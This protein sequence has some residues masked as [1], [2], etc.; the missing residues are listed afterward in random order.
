MLGK[1]KGRRFLK[2]TLIWTLIA[3]VFTA[4]YSMGLYLLYKDGI[5]RLKDEIILM[6]NSWFH[7]Y[8]ISNEGLLLHF[9]IEGNYVYFGKIEDD[10]SLKDVYKTDYGAFRLSGLDN[11]NFRSEDPYYSLPDS[12]NV[13]FDFYLTND[14]H[15]NS[16]LHYNYI[17]TWEGSALDNHGRRDPDGGKFNEKREYRIYN[18]FCPGY[19]FKAISE[20]QD[21]GVSLVRSLMPREEFYRDYVFYRYSDYDL[22]NKIY[23][24]LG[25]A[26][27]WVSDHLIHISEDDSEGAYIYHADIDYI[28]GK[29]LSGELCVN[30]ERYSFPDDNSSYSSTTLKISLHK[31]PDSILANN[32]DLLRDNFDQAYL[33]SLKYQSKPDLYNY[34]KEIIDRSG[35]EGFTYDYKFEDGQAVASGI[36]KYEDGYYRYVYII[37]LAGFWEVFTPDIAEAFLIVLIPGL[38]IGGLF[39]S[40]I[41]KK[42]YV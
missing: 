34:N 6:S 18:L 12:D 38:I 35:L 42:R 30:G 13:L 23:R 21:S 17:T 33:E 39:S 20:S 8:H 16:F 11:A 36:C 37:P 24:V 31:R 2:F 41:S 4:A 14:T 10:G 9:P 19:V 5:R 29:I 25:K 27:V 1:S 15:R 28:Q 22:L 26:A 40:V 7:T 3:A 32:K